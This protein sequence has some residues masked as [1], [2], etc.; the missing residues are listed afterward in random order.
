MKKILFGILAFAFGMMVGVANAE[1]TK[2]LKFVWN[3]E[4][5]PSDLAG[6]NIYIGDT[7]VATYSGPDM[8]FSKSVL[9]SDENNCFSITAFDSAYLTDIENK[10]SHESPKSEL[11]CI[12]LPPGTPS[13]FHV[14]IDAVITIDKMAPET[15]QR[16]IPAKKAKK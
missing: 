16:S 11:V 10:S 6:Y 14:T 8:S 1:V 13:M 5:V 7:I 3:M 12:N 4:N 15:L 2:N 9:M